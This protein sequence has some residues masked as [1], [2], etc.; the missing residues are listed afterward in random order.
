MA[1]DFGLNNQPV[2]EKQ[3]LDSYSVSLDFVF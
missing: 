2:D 3:E 1:A